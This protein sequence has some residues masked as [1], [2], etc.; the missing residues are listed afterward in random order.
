MCFQPT[1]T[2]ENYRDIKDQVCYW[3]GWVRTPLF[4]NPSHINHFPAT[5]VHGPKI[6]NI[7][8]IFQSHSLLPQSFTSHFT[9]S[10]VGQDWTD[11]SLDCR[12]HSHFF[13]I[14]ASLVNSFYSRPDVSYPQIRCNPPAVCVTRSESFEWTLSDLGVISN[15]IMVYGTHLITV[16]Y[17]INL[18]WK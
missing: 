3:I 11:G 18:G 7:A 8:H 9:W 4:R 14:S 12:N 6:M 1:W 16:P 15:L 17:W 2:K 10:L 13:A 5:I